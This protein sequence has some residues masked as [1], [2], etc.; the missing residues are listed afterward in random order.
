[1]GIKKGGPKKL[2]KVIHV[3]AVPENDGCT[4]LIAL[5]DD[6][7]IWH[8][9][10]GQNDYANKDIQEWTPMKP[11]PTTVKDAHDDL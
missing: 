1:M 3:Q 4:R 10:F 2:P 5:T 7:Q 8:G 6:G 9:W 11:V